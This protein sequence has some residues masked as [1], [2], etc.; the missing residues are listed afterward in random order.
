MY[1]GDAA[2]ALGFGG[3]GVGAV[4]EVRVGVVHGRCAVGSPAGVGDAGR[5]LK[6]LGVHLLLQLGHA[7]CAA[8]AVQSAG[9]RVAHAGLVHGHAA[10]VITTVLEALQALDQDG[11]DVALGYRADDAAHKGGLLGWNKGESVRPVFASLAG[12][13]H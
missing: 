1:Q 7:R 3:G 4:A 12:R 11:N 6:M 8:C 10:G 9:G 13:A 5:T 2:S